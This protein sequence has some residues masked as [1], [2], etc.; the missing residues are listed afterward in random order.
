[1]MKKQ[2]GLVLATAVF[3]GSLTVPVAAET[4][5]NST[6][7]H[8]LLFISPSCPHCQE[9]EDFLNE[10]PQLD[11]TVHKYR[12]SVNTGLFANYTQAYEVPQRLRGSVPSAF[13]GEEYRVGSQPVIQMIE[14]KTSSNETIPKP[15]LSDKLEK[16]QQKQ[17]NSGQKLTLIGVTGL[18][19]V[20][21]VN[22]CALAVLII[23]LTSILSQNPD[24]KK[25]ALKSGLSFSAAV[26]F[27]YLT[28]GLLIILGFKSVASTTAVQSS[29]IYTTVG[30]LAVLLGLFNLKD[31]FSHGA[32]GFRMEV[33][34]SWRPKMKIYIRKAT[35]PAGAFLSGLIVSLFLLPCTSGPY[36]VAGG[37]LSQM[38][39]LTAA[40]WLILYNAV[41]ILPMVAITAAV[42]GGFASVE[43][44]SDWREENIEKLHLIAG[45]ILIAIGTAVATGLI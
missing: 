25:E 26:L 9:V 18:A 42:Y 40:P 4:P 34:I 22:P 43:K 10:N 12:A 5:E 44:I 23:L 2:I 28:M 36:F 39:L 1:M 7:K 3:L 41:F 14:S 8:L 29:M 6:E 37:L 21:A 19:L 33:P 32:F 35:S 15:D 20:D 24:K 13:M 38:N 30:L 16:T 45:I 17:E 31:Y 11:L 27:A